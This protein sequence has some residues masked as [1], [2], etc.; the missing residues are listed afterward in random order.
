[1][2]KELI[3]A[4][5][6]R[7]SSLDADACGAITDIRPFSWP[8]IRRGKG[9]AQVMPGTFQAYK[10]STGGDEAAQA[11]APSRA[12]RCG[13]GLHQMLEA[14][15]SVTVSPW[16]MTRP[17][18]KAGQLRQR[19]FD[20]VGARDDALAGLT[21]PFSVSV[22]LSPPRVPTAVMRRS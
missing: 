11:R 12:V 4:I 16:E 1:M 7:E 15:L 5:A 19:P 6:F 21:H 2:S 3:L 10:A 8:M 22:L 14:S 13:C 20:G 17:G 18:L 9:M